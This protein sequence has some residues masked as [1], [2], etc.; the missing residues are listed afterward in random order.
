MKKTNIII[1]TDPGVDD[2]T[3]ITIA[4]FN[5][6]LSVK[7]ITTTNGNVGID[8]TTNN[9]LFLVEKF[10]KNVPVCKGA[11]KPLKREL[12]NASFVHGKNGLGGI[13][14]TKPTREICSEK[15]VDK[16][17]EIIKQNAGNITILE[18]APHT[19]LGLL[20]TKYP[21]C[22][23]MISEIIFEGGSPYGKQG[24]KPHI[25]FNISCDPEACDIVLKTKIKKTIVPS[26]IGRYIAYL[27]K[28]QVETI[29]KTN[30]TGEFFAKM[31]EGYKS[32]AIFDATET[33]DLSAVLYLLYPE[34]FETYSCD[35]E[36]DLIDKPGKT[37]IKEN[38]NGKVTFVE[39]CDREKFFDKFIENLKSIDF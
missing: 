9:A 12:K 33:N 3:A 35:V 2:A 17:Y 39:N 11:E 7:L 15:A 30:K 24:V 31:F 21:D 16:M 4:L 6:N 36:V 10:N 38:H 19:N 8:T 28:N 23:N 37:T 20:F 18:L 25:S 27:T 34:I 32:D 26:E 22:E 29:K 5:E 13:N 1:D 14:P